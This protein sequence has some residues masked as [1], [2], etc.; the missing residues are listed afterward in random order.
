[1]VIGPFGAVAEM[2]GVKA[3]THVLY[4]FASPDARTEANEGMRA[5]TMGYAVFPRYR[6]RYA[7]RGTLD[8][9]WEQPAT[10]KMVAGVQFFMDGT[11]LVITHMAVRPKWRRS[12][13]NT[14]LLDL[15][16]EGA[17]ATSVEFEEPTSEGT[18][19]MRSYGGREYKPK[20]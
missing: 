5:G 19:F 9:F 1:M 12:R 10:K 20:R 18:E 3:A 11:K 6:S 16:V 13:I 17:K 2:F 15:I 4:L 7:T 14:W 8:M